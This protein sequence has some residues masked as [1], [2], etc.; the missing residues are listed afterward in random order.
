MQFPNPFGPSHK[1]F[2]I[3]CLEHSLRPQVPDS[4]PAL[5]RRVTLEVAA[6]VVDVE[7][8]EVSEAVGLEEPPGEVHRH[9]V[10]D[11]A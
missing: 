7:A 4:G 2:N 5:A 10:V 3:S 9:H 8:H 6:D 11:A 1:R